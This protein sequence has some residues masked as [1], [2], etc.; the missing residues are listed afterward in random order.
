MSLILILHVVDSTGLCGIEMLITDDTFSISSYRLGG[1]ESIS[2]DMKIRIKIKDMG[3]NNSS[4]T[5]WAQKS[6][7]SLVGISFYSRG[8][9]SRWN[10]ERLEL[11]SRSGISERDNSNVLKLHFAGDNLP[12][13]F[14]TFSIFDFAFSHQCLNTWRVSFCEYDFPGAVPGCKS[15]LKWIMIAQTGLW[16]IR[17]ADIIPVAGFGK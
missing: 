17:Y 6:Q 7:Q 8:L 4:L 10:R 5:P 12:D 11:A 9:Q 15:S 3:T 16:V 14:N 13:E 1:W 2:C